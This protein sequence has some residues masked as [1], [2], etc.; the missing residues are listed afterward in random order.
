MTDD[1]NWGERKPEPEPVYES[2]IY[3]KSLFEESFEDY[4][5]NFEKENC[6]KIDPRKQKA[7]YLDL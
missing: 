4:E 5:Y 2:E 6:W 3:G 7:D 1:P